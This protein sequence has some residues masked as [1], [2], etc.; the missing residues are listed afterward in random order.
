MEKRLVLVALVTLA[1]G[2]GETQGATEDAGSDADV[3]DLGRLDVAVDEM[4]LVEVV[5]SSCRLEQDS[6]C[7]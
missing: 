2:C 7:R 4:I 5:K 3:V 1:L 6:F